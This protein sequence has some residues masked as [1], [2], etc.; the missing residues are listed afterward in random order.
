MLPAGTVQSPCYVKK[1]PL[2]HDSPHH[3]ERGM[4]IRAPPGALLRKEGKKPR[5]D[6]P[7]GRLKRRYE[8][9]FI[10]WAPSIN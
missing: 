9:P 2:C 6:I 4:V 5:E 8:N 3:I 10:I 7:A 1:H